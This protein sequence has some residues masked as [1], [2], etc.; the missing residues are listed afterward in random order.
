MG[1]AGAIRNTARSVAMGL[2]FTKNIIQFVKD[3]ASETIGTAKSFFQKGGNM[4]SKIAMGAVGGAL[5]AVKDVY[6]NTTQVDLGAQMQSFATT[7]GMH[8]VYP[9]LWADGGGYSKS[10]TFD[11]NFT[12]PY[13]D[14]LS[15][16]KYVYV[17]FC[18]LLCFTM[19]R[20]A[21]DNGYVSPFF[22][23]ADMPGLFTCDL[24]LISNI[25]YTRGGPNGLFTKDGLP[26]AIS[27]NFSIEDLYPYLAM[28]RRISFLSANPSYTSFLDTFT[29]FNAVYTTNDTSEINSYWRNMLNRVNGEHK[30][31]LWNKF[32]SD[33][34][35]AN[36]LAANTVTES[37]FTVRPKSINW[38]R[39]T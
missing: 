38:F 28:S 34:R 22:V 18:T 16:F 37:N 19:P 12:S 10:M 14:P 24:G 6:R 20:A 27:G 30:Y 3:A 8:V 32:D 4:I 11:F 31:T 36:Y 35:R 15:I 23:R 1:K 2:S 21:D 29:G 26:R 25:S 9:D 39:K 33:G 17:P 5:G 13:G 7:N